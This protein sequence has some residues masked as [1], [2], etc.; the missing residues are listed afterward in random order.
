MP[1]RIPARGQTA[2]NDR[3]GVRDHGALVAAKRR[4]AERAAPNLT[5]IGGK[6][7][8]AAICPAIAA[9]AVRT[10]RGVTPLGA[11]TANGKTRKAARESGETNRKVI[12]LKRTHLRG[13]KGRLVLIVPFRYYQFFHRIPLI[14][15]HASVSTSLRLPPKLDMSSFGEFARRTAR[16][17]TRKK[18]DARLNV[19]P[20]RIPVARPRSAVFVRLRPMAAGL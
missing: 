14:A 8:L 17:P 12:P 9:A 19:R 1:N 10:N 13:N 15:R 16:V 11:N 4:N 20:D 7:G 18:S 3:V 6:A 5:G 2:W